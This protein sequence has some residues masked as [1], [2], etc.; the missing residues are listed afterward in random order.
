MPWPVQRHLSHRQVRFA[1]VVEHPRD[2]QVGGEM[3]EAIGPE[4]AGVDPGIRGGDCGGVHGPRLQHGHGPEPGSE[5]GM[6][7]G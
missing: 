3:D 2:A 5:R 6:L 7:E 1:L 4:L